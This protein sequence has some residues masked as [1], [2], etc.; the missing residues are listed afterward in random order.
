MTCL[1][2]LSI[3]SVC[4]HAHARTHTFCV[5]CP[6]SHSSLPHKLIFR[7]FGCRALLLMHTSILTPFMTDGCDRCA[8]VFF[9]SFP[10]RLSSAYKF[11]SGRN[12]EIRQRR[13][14]VGRHFQSLLSGI[15]ETIMSAE[16]LSRPASTSEGICVLHLHDSLRSSVEGCIT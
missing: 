12:E 5:T 1:V 9:F 3:G 11:A 2:S 7:A 13:R 8:N 16:T 4:T 10:L 6:E 15:V 14:S